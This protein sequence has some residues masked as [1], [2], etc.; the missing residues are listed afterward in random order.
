MAKREPCS[1]IVIFRRD[2]LRVIVPTKVIEINRRTG[3]VSEFEREVL[4][5]QVHSKA[6]A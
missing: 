1:P 4:P 5:W 2:S 6:K 3:K